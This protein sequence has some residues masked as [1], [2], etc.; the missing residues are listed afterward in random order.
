MDLDVPPLTLEIPPS[1]TKNSPKVGLEVSMLPLSTVTKEDVLHPLRSD[2]E[3]QE[4]I[5][6][7]SP[8]KKRK[9]ADAPLEADGPEGRRLKMS[10]S[11]DVVGK[12]KAADHVMEVINGEDS[13]A[14]QVVTKT[15]T[16]GGRR[17]RKKAI[18]V[19]QAPLGTDASVPPLRRGRSKAQPAA[20]AAE[21]GQEA[22]T[23]EVHHGDSFRGW[24]RGRSKAQQAAMAAEVGQEAQTPEVTKLGLV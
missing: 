4:R 19:K 9:A 22:Q 10:K 1:P 23:P 2:G 15:K 5:V 3:F 24:G 6:A 21:V 8:R 18:N 11:P 13:G 14:T 20:M 17:G 16:T 7:E 12:A